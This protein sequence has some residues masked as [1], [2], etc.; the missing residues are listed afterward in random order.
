M[1]PRAEYPIVV[2]ATDSGDGAQDIVLFET[3]DA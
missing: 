2:F 3:A 1:E